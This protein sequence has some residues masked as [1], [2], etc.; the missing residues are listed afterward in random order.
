MKVVMMGLGYI[1]LPTAALIASKKINVLGVDINKDVCTIIN[2]GKIHIVE[3]DLDG[4]V[5]QVVN[6]GYFKASDTPDKADVYIIAVPTPF[7]ENHDPDISYIENA[8]N[9]ILPLLEKGNLIILESTS[10]IKTTDKIAEQIFSSRPEL[11]NNIYLAYCPER[12]LPGEVLH[13]LVYNDRV[14]GGLNDESTDRAIEFY[15]IFVKGK[16][17]KTNSRTAEMCK[18]VENAYRDVNIAFA[19]EL[20]MISGAADINVG[21]LIELANKH[22]RVNILNPGPGVGGHCIAIDPW[23]V[24]SD[25]KKEAK[26]I[27]CARDVNLSKT[28]WVLKKIQDTIGKFKN[29]KKGDPVIACMGLSYKADIDDLRESPALQIT[30]ELKENGNKIVVVEPNID[31]LEGYEIVNHDEVYE[32]ADIIVFL[33]AHKEFKNMHSESKKIILDFCGVFQN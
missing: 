27:R 11:S 31:E 17:H 7:K 6:A 5:H 30:S 13:E 19:N 25:F 14:I 10:P 12:V 23:F 3:P 24:I 8:T 18:L 21:E 28:D 15:S 4:L 2:D 20:S 16:L 32:V 9:M 26:I 33:V 22:P 29:E 1:G